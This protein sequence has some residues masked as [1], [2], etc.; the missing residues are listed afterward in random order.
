MSV[1]GFLSHQLLEVE[2]ELVAA[3]KEADLLGLDIGEHADEI[4][5][6]KTLA[7]DATEWIKKAAVTRH[8]LDRVEGLLRAY[9]LHLNANRGE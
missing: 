5:W 6:D 2:A 4:H 8:R 3:S 7:S 1:R 9:N